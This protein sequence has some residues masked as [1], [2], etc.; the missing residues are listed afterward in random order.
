MSLLKS[1]VPLHPKDLQV[2]AH[3]FAVRQKVTQLT[4]GQIKTA[5]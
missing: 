5:N 1:E 4:F 3:H 2:R